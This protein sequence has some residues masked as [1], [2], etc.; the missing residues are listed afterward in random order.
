MKDYTLPP[1][2]EFEHFATV[3]HRIGADH[4]LTLMKAVMNDYWFDN[5]IKGDWTSE[6][7]DEFIHKIYFCWQEYVKF[8]YG[9]E[10]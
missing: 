8:R 6:V 3:G 10:E 2:W 7:I 4:W 1:T 9:E 5:P